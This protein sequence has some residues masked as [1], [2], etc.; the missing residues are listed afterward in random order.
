MFGV[1]GCGFEPVSA[2]QEG[3]SGAPRIER[4][5]RLIASAQFGIHDLSRVGLD[6]RSGLPRFNMP[7]ELGMDLGCRAFGSKAQRRKK[8]LI[9]DSERYRY[10][11]FLSDIAGQDIRDHGNS[12][13]RLFKIVREFLGSRAHARVTPGQRWLE[14][15]FQA[16]TDALPSLCERSGLERQA[17]AFPDF[18]RYATSWVARARKPDGA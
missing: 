10:Q 11:V 5:A 15:Q 7:F 12:I 4:I 1:V 2:L 17:L 16:F 3:D 13:S 6:D 18:V 8:I 14:T 9:L